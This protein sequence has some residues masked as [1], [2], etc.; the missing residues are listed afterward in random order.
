MRRYQGILLVLGA[1]TLAVGCGAQS[2]RDRARSAPDGGH[3]NLLTQAD[4]LP[5][6]HPR[7]DPH[8]PW[9]LLPEGHPPIQDG[10]STCPRRSVAPGAPRE[11]GGDGSPDVPGVISI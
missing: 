11:F 2:D 8:H 9:L 3:P 4:V 7:V 1:A 5:E 10:L 6:G